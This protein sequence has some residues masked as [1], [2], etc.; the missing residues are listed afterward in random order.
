MT[1][2]YSRVPQ[3][4]DRSEADTQFLDGI[5]R[6]HLA[7]GQLADLSDSATNAEII[8]KINELIAIFRTR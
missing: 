8:D 1:I 6:R 4:D 2:R 3:S 7:V 5:D